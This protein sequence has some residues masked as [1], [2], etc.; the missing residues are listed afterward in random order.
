MNM[1]SLHLHNRGQKIIRAVKQEQGN[2]K[3]VLLEK[4][5]QLVIRLIHFSLHQLIR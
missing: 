3:H 4:L 5:L 1:F 2:L